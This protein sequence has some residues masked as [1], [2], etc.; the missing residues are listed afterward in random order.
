MVFITEKIFDFIG[1][2]CQ[3]AR[4]MPSVSITN[5]FPNG[6]ELLKIR[7]APHCLG[8]MRILADIP[9]RRLVQRKPFDLVG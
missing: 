4:P 3:A 1:T 8:R 9:D 6:V 7:V 2:T 5:R